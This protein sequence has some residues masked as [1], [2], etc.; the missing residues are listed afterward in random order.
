[1]R[2]TGPSFLRGSPSVAAMPRGLACRQ[3]RCNPPPLR[4]AAGQWHAMPFDAERA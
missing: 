4:R 2:L 3:A 1:L